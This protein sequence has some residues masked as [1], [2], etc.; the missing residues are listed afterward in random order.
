VIA[1]HEILL[2]PRGELSALCDSLGLAFDPAMLSWPVGPRP[3]DGV[4]APHWYASVHRSSGF[5]PYVRKTRPVPDR[6]APLLAECRTHYEVLVGGRARRRH[7]DR[8][9]TQAP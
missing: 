6:L 1:A 9:G 5:Q 7:P 8:H 2:D 4:W 3:E